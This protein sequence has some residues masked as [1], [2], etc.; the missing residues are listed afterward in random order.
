[1]RYSDSSFQTVLMWRRRMRN[2]KS[3]TPGAIPVRPINNVD[4]SGITVVETERTELSL[5]TPPV[6]V[7]IWT[8]ESPTSATN[9]PCPVKPPNVPG[10]QCPNISRFRNP[11]TFWTTT[12]EVLLKVPKRLLPKMKLVGLVRL[13]DTGPK[14]C[15]GMPANTPL[16][17]AVDTRFPIMK[18]VAV[19]MF[20]MGTPP[21]VGYRTRRK[22]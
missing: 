15:E 14:N 6:P 21:A 11:G 2:R 9:G 12:I 20:P 4:G 22:L 18:L 13:N 7:G 10:V 1:M 8:K 16:L 19:L 3:M 5:I 17:F